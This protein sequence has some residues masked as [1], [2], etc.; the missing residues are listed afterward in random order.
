MTH[1]PLILPS[2]D[3]KG[4]RWS[5]S[6][7][8]EA[9]RLLEIAQPVEI[10][11]S[12]GTRRIGCHRYFPGRHSITISRFLTAEAASRV[13]W[14]ELTHA[15]QVERAIRLHGQSGL[16]KFGQAYKLE[17]RMRGYRGNRFE[18]EAR[19]AEDWHEAQ[20]LAA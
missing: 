19:A 12:Q 16:S 11:F 9:L 10:K 20:P 18:V 14:H 5:V 13:L 1:R 2:R 7:I 4:I 17:T 3:V 8:E 6:G 15:A